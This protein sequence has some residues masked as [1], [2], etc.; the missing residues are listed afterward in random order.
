M[1]AS[2]VRAGDLS[3]AMDGAFAGDRKRAAVLMGH[4]WQIRMGRR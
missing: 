3:M 2:Q 1:A 4:K